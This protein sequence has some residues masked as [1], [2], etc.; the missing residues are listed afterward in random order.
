MDAGGKFR[1]WSED[2]EQHEDS[3]V[4]ECAKVLGQAAG[5]IAILESENVELMEQA[6][7]LPTDLD[8]PMIGEPC[9]FAEKGFRPAMEGWY[10]AFRN[11]ARHCH[12]V[13]QNYYEAQFAALAEI[14]KAK[15]KAAEKAA[16]E[17]REPA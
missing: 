13:R 14:A 5:V 2:L 16:S 10:N 3:M 9:L 17:E 1:R 6:L 4:R 8:V 15:W 11:A 7:I 12:D